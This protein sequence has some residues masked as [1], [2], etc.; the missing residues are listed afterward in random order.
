MI[1]MD[2]TDKLLLSGLLGQMCLCVC[3][4]CGEC[5]IALNTQESVNTPRS[6]V[7][8]HKGK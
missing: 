2:H 6:K 7:N 3:V 5:V 4:S 8:T 1:M